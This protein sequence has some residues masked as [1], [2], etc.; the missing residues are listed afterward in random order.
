[1]SEYKEMDTIIWDSWT[2]NRKRIP[3]KVVSQCGSLYI[4]PEG[5]GDCTSED[6]H[7]YPICLEYY[8]GSLRLIVWSDINQ[9]DPTHIIPMEGSYT[10]QRKGVYADKETE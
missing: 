9:E 5:T 4:R 3:V 6:G 7:G 1:M 2:N 10:S 8:E